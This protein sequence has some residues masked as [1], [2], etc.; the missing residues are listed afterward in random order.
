MPL[1][2]ALDTN[3]LLRLA[4]RSQPQHELIMTALRR[5]VARDVKLCFTPQNLGEFWNASTRPLDRNGFGLS[6]QEASEQIRSI[7]RRVSLL[8]ESERV[9]EIWKRLLL[10]HG[11]RGVQVHDA[12]LAAV[13]AV[14]DVTHLLT[15]NGKD[16][17]RFPS[18]ISVHPAEV[19][20]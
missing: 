5:L 13:L 16:F 17:K 8:P 14:H 11:V 2:Y 4:H 12:H 9:Y 15:L 20:P 6:P 1:R 10:V 18:L 3:V 19:Q 7:E